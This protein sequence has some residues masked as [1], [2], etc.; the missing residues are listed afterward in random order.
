MVMQLRSATRNMVPPPSSDSAAGSVE[1][2]APMGTSTGNGGE[3]GESSPSL[4]APTP[5]LDKL[6]HSAK[7]HSS[8]QDDADETGH[9]SRSADVGNSDHSRSNADVASVSHG[10]LHEDEG[11]MMDGLQPS[12]PAAFQDGGEVSEAA[13]H[14][15]HQD[16][17]G[18]SV[19]K[20]SSCASSVR[21]GSP[22]LE[23]ALKYFDKWFFPDDAAAAANPLGQPLPRHVT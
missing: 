4:S 20:R 12:V 14:D 22:V 16:L 7:T 5:S 19:P 3:L 2:D 21:S 23:M 10:V 8:N 1:M 17:R 11:A 13:F 15:G 18:F 6:G 9:R